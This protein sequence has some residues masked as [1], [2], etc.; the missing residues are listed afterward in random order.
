MSDKMR[1]KMSDRAR[2]RV[3]DKVR[4][5]KSEVALQV[6]SHLSAH[7]DVSQRAIAA[8]LGVSLG[9]INYCLKALISR[10][11]IKAENFRKSSNKIG[12]TYLLTPSGVREKAQLTIAFLKRKQQEYQ[13]LE[14]EITALSA[15]VAALEKEQLL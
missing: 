11:F 14:Q 2:D 12:Y 10:G 7:P 15:Q 1:D 3:R 13:Q 5:S 6:L 9:G 4:K 8:E